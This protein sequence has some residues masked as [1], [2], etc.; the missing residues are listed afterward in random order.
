MGLKKAFKEKKAQ[1]ILVSLLL[2]FAA[3]VVVSTLL[4]P[5][6][7]FTDFAVNATQNSTNGALIATLLQFIPVFLVLVLVISLFAIVSTR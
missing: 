2:F 1:F 5:I 3:L 6:I 4:G 7:T